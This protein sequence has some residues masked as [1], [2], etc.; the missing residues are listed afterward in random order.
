MRYV[1]CRCIHAGTHSV[2][3]PH[4]RSVDAAVDAWGFAWAQGHDLNDTTLT[5]PV[6]FVVPLTMRMNGTPKSASGR[7]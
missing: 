3:A 2:D 7:L 6:E 4:S 1:A 5:V